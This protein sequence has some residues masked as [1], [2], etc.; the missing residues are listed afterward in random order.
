MYRFSCG[1]SNSTYHR[2]SLHIA[3][4]Q[5][6]NTTVEELLVAGADRDRPLQETGDW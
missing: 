6:H 5:G 2:S 1:V 4:T 3:V